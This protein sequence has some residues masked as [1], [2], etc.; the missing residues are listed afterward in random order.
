MTVLTFEGLLKQGFVSDTLDSVSLGYILQI[1]KH[2]KEL[3]MTELHPAVIT[4]RSC[5]YLNF[6]NGL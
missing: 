2:T 1:C 6:V 3:Y 4:C 5:I